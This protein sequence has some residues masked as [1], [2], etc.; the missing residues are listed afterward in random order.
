[1]G[2]AF[3]VAE[4]IRAAVDR[5]GKITISLGVACLKEGILKQ[6]ELIRKADEALYEAKRLGR[7]RVVA[8]DSHKGIMGNP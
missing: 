4:R 6:D 8:A 7:N 2:K 3:E 1:M 5:A